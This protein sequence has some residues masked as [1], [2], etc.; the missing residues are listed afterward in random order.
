MTTADK[1]RE[2][3]YEDMVRILDDEADKTAREERA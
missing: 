3:T 2:K 1:V